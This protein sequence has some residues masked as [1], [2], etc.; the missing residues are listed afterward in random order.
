MKTSILFTG[1]LILLGF[2]PVSVISVSGQRVTTPILSVIPKTG[3]FYGVQLGQSRSLT[4]TLKNKGVSILNIKKVEIVGERF[5]LTDS[6]TYPFEVVADSGVAFST[7][8]SGK[9]ITFSVEFSPM[10]TGNFTGKIIITYGL[11]SD[12]IYEIQLT[13]KGLSCNDAIEAKKGENYVPALDVWYKYTADKFSIVDIN[14]CHPKQVNSSKNPYRLVYFYVYDGCNGYLMPEVDEWTGS[15]PYD[16]EAIPVWLVMNPG[17]TVYILLPKVYENPAYETNGYYF[18]INVTYP[19]D[20]DVCENAIPLTLPV[21][22]LFGNTR[23]LNDDYNYSP[24]S[25]YTNYMD[26]ND[27][28][29]TITLP[30]DGYLIGDIIGAYGSIHVLDECPKVELPKDYCKAFTG[31]PNGGHFR[32]KIP[33]GTYYVIISNWA[34]PQTLDYLLNLS[35]EGTSAVE[36]ESLVNSLN[37]YPNPAHQKFIVSFNS[38]AENDLKMELINISG[39]VVYR[40]ELKSVFSIQEEIDASGFAKGV[41]Y[42]KVNTSKE[43]VVRKVIVK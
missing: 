31:G 33:A 13:G 12:E 40:H 32:K 2:A 21:V 9:A 36:N 42:L 38:A 19:I 25:P 20:G 27:I 15:C 14:S 4:F 18:N 29:Y 11:W 8:N 41:Y 37:V 10:E 28:V 16:R 35:W 5:T 3:E 23:G 1:M 17:Q 26:G 39:Q 30:E 7:G 34:P 43:T 22:N 6:N 24:C